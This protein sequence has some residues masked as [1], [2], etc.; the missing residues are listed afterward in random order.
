MKHRFISSSACQV[1]ALIF[2][3]GDEVIEGLTTFAR[4]HDLGA[5]YFSGLGAM[6][7]A[8]L[9]FFDP[10]SKEYEEIPVPEQVEVLSLIGN[11]TVFE[12][13]ARVHAHAVLGQHDGS[14]IGGH[15][16]RGIIRPTLE[17]FI[18]ALPAEL[19]REHDADSGLPLITL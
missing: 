8:T 5:A 2:E 11:L 7:E 19:R 1:W 16:Q 15:L 10:D 6:S 14:T 4:E 17:V 9:A 13:T 3:P 18:T 12:G